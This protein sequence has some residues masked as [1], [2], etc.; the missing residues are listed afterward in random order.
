MIWSYQNDRDLSTLLKFDS[1]NENENNFFFTNLTDSDHGGSKNNYKI[2]EFKKC[3]II[4]LWKCHRQQKLF[5]K[6]SKKLLTGT[7]DLLLA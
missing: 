4:Y 6:F 3:D 1:A 2:L 5:L 7:A